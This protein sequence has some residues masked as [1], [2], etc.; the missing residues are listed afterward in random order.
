MYSIF[1][2]YELTLRDKLAVWR[3]IMANERT[4]MSYLS[5][6]ITLIIAGVTIIKFFAQ[7][8]FFSIFWFVVIFFWVCFILFWVSSYRKRKKEIEEICNKQKE[9]K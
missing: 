7:D 4:L 2:N 9:K 6:W 3:N 5:S 8:K 1:K